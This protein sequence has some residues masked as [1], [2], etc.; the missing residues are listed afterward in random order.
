MIERSAFD[1]VEGALG[2]H[3]L[4]R[5]SMTRIHCVVM[6]FV[7]EEAANGRGV[8]YVVE[9]DYARIVATSDGADAALC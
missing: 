2:Q 8:S 7:S 4:T 9:R 5:E 3:K 1:T 6:A